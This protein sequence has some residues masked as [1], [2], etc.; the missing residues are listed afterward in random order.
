MTDFTF[1]EFAKINPSVSFVHTFP[2]GVKT[3]FAKETGFAIRAASNL[4]LI[5]GSPWMTPIGESGE[6]HLYTATSAR[7]PA[8]NG[9]EAGVNAIGEQVIKGS[10]G[11]AGSGA[12]LIGSGNEFRANEKVLEELRSKDAGPKILEHTLKTFKDIKGS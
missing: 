11:E 9:T 3:G 7:Y 6:R 8:K 10:T 12:Y 2:G 5:L 4:A 1:E